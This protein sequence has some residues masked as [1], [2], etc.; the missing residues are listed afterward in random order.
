MAGLHGI[1][2]Y[3]GHQ[4][5]EYSFE[6]GMEGY[7]MFSCANLKEDSKG[8]IWFGN[9]GIRGKGSGAIRYDG[10]NFTLFGKKYWAFIQESDKPQN[11]DWEHT[12]N[13]IFEDSHEQIWWTTQGSGIMRYNG[14]QI[15]HYTQ[16]DG[17]LSNNN[18]NILED[19][20][21]NIWF[22]SGWGQEEP[23]KGLS[24]YIPPDDY[25]QGIGGT[26]KNYTQN[27][28]LSSGHIRE[29]MEDSKGNLWFSTPDNGINRFNGETFTHITEEQGLNASALYL[30]EDRN[31]NIWTGGI[32]KNGTGGAV[33]DEKMFRFQPNSYVHFSEKQG[34]NAAVS[35]I[36]EDS[37]GNIWFGTLSGGIIKYD[38]QSYTHFT[39]EEG[40]CS[41]EV[42]AIIEDQKGNLWIA[43]QN[44][45]V[46]RFDGKSFTN[47]APRQGIT[48]NLVWD[49]FEDR[50]GNMW[51][52]CGTQG[53]V[54]RLNTDTG[55][56]THYSDGI[57][58]NK[59]SYGIGSSSFHEDS[60]GNLWAGGTGWLMK[61]NLLHDQF[62]ILYRMDSVDK[63]WIEY[64][65]E[66][67]KGNLWFGS[68]SRLF[69]M[70]GKETNDAKKITLFTK[71]NGLPDCKIQSIIE[72][73]QKNIWI[74]SNKGLALLVGGLENIGK[75]DWIQFGKSDGLKCN[76]YTNR[77][78]LLD[79]KNRMW[80]GTGISGVTMLDLNTYQLPTKAPENLSLSHIEINQEFL[81]Y[82]SLAK[83]NYNNAFAFGAVLKKTID[84]VVAFQNYPATLKLPYDLNHL[85]F[86][87]SAV[88]WAAPHKIQYSYLMEGLDK[89]WSQFQK[90]TQADYRNIPHGSYTF[91]VGC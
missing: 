22:G 12:V 46:S 71:E 66:D 31:N 15:I 82:R 65:L 89:E 61:H 62:D 44:N 35:S 78:V 21:G 67:D 54:V 23:M 57:V 75:K 53:G 81:D 76:G 45:G 56:F 55:Q 17:I 84:S 64:M 28:G 91:K 87:F 52:A 58:Y 88:D 2:S 5:T 18:A 33:S 70:E 25:P 26:F 86:H 77:S 41:N 29:I 32:G 39:K 48:F 19:K 13:G 27:E 20:N 9:Q 90:T 1:Y 63:E 11:Y 42:T 47:Y 37:K 59:E 68:E 3:D 85:T 8:N 6:E 60:K 79:S 40:L 16:K 7:E 14:Q 10:T 83:V 80:W 24:C 50:A 72:D 51:F 69:R 34:L 36:L 30:T 49:A 38:G 4:I 73:H 74:S 43:T